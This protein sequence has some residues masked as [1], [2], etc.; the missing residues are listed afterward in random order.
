M[1]QILDAK[2]FVNIVG[3]WVGGT[4]EELELD[5]RLFNDYWQLDRCRACCL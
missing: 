3:L 1:A 5:V 2:E 4:L